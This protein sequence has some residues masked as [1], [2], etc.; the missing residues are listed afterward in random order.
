MKNIV[1]KGIDAKNAA[2]AMKVAR[3]DYPSEDYIVIGGSA[4]IVGDKPKEK[5]TVWEITLRERTKEEKKEFLRW[6]MKYAEE[7]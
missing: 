4:S 7:D 2:S 6:E 1:L 3:K 5:K